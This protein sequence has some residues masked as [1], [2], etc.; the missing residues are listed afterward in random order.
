MQ[1]THQMA[2]QMGLETL[3]EANRLLEF[4]NA[5]I[6]AS[7][8]GQDHILYPGAYGVDV[9]AITDKD[10]FEY[11]PNEDYLITDCSNVDEAGQVPPDRSGLA[12]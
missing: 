4:G 11:N 10:H 3:A 1:L 6:E 5:L 7:R 2:Q 9:H 8:N 12:A